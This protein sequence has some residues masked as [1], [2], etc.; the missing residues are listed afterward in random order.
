M[1][2]RPVP[3]RELADVQRRPHRVQ[4]RTPS[5]GPARAVSSPWH[6]RTRWKLF[7]CTS[8]MPQ[9]KRRLRDSRTELGHLST[10]AGLQCL[11]LRPQIFGVL[12]EPLAAAPMS[13]YFL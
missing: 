13:A 6:R 11:K 8:A 1:L 12:R 5:H 10:G 9:W 2:T 4:W 3:G 7:D